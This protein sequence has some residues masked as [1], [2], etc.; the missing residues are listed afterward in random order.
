MKYVVSV[1]PSGKMC[2][3]H[4]ND[5][6]DR[7][8][9]AR[10]PGRFVCQK[11]GAESYPPGEQPNKKLNSRLSWWGSVLLVIA[12]GYLIVG[13]IVQGIIGLVGWIW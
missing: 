12:F 3:L 5:E 13:L 7:V 4:P 9:F 11:C 10:G 2:Y 1:A 6:M 8:E